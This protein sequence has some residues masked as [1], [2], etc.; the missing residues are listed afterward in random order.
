MVVVSLTIT[1]LLM[2]SGRSPGASTVRAS[3]FRRPKKPHRLPV[4]ELDA[5][6]LFS[7]HLP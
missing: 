1:S 7:E 5:P 6:L 3:S 4:G 2:K